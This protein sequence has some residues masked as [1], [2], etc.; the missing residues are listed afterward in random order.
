MRMRFGS[1]IAFKSISIFVVVPK[2]E[3]IPVKVSPGLTL[4]FLTVF[5]ELGGLEAGLESV[6]IVAGRLTD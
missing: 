2:L 5:E 3:A 1:V 4:Y 6:V